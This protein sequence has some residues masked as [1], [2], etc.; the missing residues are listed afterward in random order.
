MYGLLSVNIYAEEQS[1]LML[2]TKAYKEQSLDSANEVCLKQKEQA[3]KNDDAGQNFAITRVLIKINRKLRYA[4]RVKSLLQEGMLLA[5]TGLEKHTII[6]DHGSYYYHLGNYSEAEVYFKEGLE[7]AEDTANSKLIAKSLNDLGLINL[8]KLKYKEALTYFDKSL[9]IKEALQ[10]NYQAAITT[11]NIALVYYRLGENKMALDFYLETLNRYKQEL[12]RNPDSKVIVNRLIHMNTELSAV[13]SRL[14]KK[15]LS[16]SALNEVFIAIK[17]YKTAD[18]KVSRMTDL[19]EGLIEGADYQVAKKVLYET[20]SFLT[21]IKD[22]NLSRFYYLLAKVE[23]ETGQIE[24]SSVHAEKSISMAEQYKDNLILLKI[25]ELSSEIAESNGEL[26]KALNRF[27]RHTNINTTNNAEKFNKELTQVKHKL[28][29]EY[30]ERQILEKN[31]ELLLSKSKNNR[32]LL[33]LIAII[34]SLVL[35]GVV[36]YSRARLI[37]ERKKQLKMELDA[38]RTRLKELEK[39]LI[40]FN[41]YFLDADESIFV[42]S[43]SGYLIYTNIVGLNKDNMGNASVEKLSKKLSSAL[44]SAINSNGIYES[45]ISELNLFSERRYFRVTP[46]M[47]EGYFVFEF[48]AEQ[49]YSSYIQNKITMINRFEQSLNPLNQNIIDM[50]ALRVMVVDVMNLCVNAWVGMTKTNKIEFAEAS[51]IWKVSVDEGRL[52]TRSLDKYLSLKTLPKNPRLK[53]IIKTCHFLLS[54]KEVASPDREAIK[55]YLNRIIA[56][57]ES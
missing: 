13:Y 11:S 21:D 25:Y 40:N 4:S 9:V 51:K 6:R 45:E 14:G 56:F 38:H 35:I 46:I 41:N 27:K 37:R 18:I 20:K 2:C 52:R 8:K 5:A 10:L 17:E 39:P 3:G 43:D 30:Y 50:E 26:H 24:L 1:Y 44:D 48:N 53:N 31:N 34:A 47:N 23:Y 36:F 19:A 28:E 7:V 12:K 57:D 54:S 32:L 33:I 42:C 22:S 55:D 29:S 15:E 49:K 16:A